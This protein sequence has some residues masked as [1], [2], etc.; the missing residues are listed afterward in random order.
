MFAG[1]GIEGKMLFTEITADGVKCEGKN[2]KTTAFM[3]I[4]SN[5]ELERYWKTNPL[6][7]EDSDKVKITVAGFDTDVR[8]CGDYES[9][10][11]QMFYL[12]T[13]DIKFLS[14]SLAKKGVTVEEKY[15]LAGDDWYLSMSEQGDN[16][17]VYIDTEAEAL[18]KL[19]EITPEP[20][21]LDATPKVTPAVTA[22]PIA[23]LEGT[24]DATPEV[25][26]TPGPENICFPASATVELA[27]RSIKSMDKVE[28]GDR[29]KV[30]D[31]SYSTVFMFSHKMCDVEHSFVN[32]QTSSG[33][34]LSL[35]AGHY[36]YV[37]G[38][39]V[40]AGSIKVGD[41]V[42]SASGEQLTVQAV[43][44]KMLSGLYNP[45]TEHGDIIVNGVRASTFTTTALPAAAQAMLAPIRGIYTGFGI[46][47]SFLDV[48]MDALRHGVRS[49]LA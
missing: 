11:G 17:C 30:S 5:D 37:N 41:F 46:T 7:L 31:G 49:I 39:L 47:T 18:K 43:S 38:A 26:P 34:E 45:Q 20:L 29:V 10:S 8:K 15:I 35:T 1:F 3:A 2:N 42:E 28:L 9:T 23:P 25:S 24:V 33:A 40:P 48:G 16:P 27:D 13:K 4:L 14:D 21:P 19:E 32:V 12:R 44:R 6:K 22:Q 36:I